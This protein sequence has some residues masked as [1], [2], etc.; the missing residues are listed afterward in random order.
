MVSHWVTVKWGEREWGKNLREAG[1]L[2]LCC[3]VCSKHMQAPSKFLMRKRCRC[4]LS[5]WVSISARGEKKVQPEWISQHQ[6]VYFPVTPKTHY[7]WCSE[8]NSTQH[9]R[10]IRRFCLWQT[11]AFYCYHSVILIIVM[12]QFLRQNLFLSHNLMVLYICAV[13]ILIGHV[14]N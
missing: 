8:E 4:R 9:L 10:G 12:H 13:H 2:L 14:G 1:A 5:S 7:Y 11:Y 6:A 3:S